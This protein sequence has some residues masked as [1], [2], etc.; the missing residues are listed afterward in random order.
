M[1]D[2]AKEQTL[3]LPGVPAPRK[4]PGPKP[5]GKAMTTAQRQAKFRARHQ[6]VETGERI[7]ATIRAL[8]RQFDLTESAVTFA[9]C[10]KDWKRAG[11]P[12]AVTK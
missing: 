6:R 3:N 12:Q 1:R 4:R 2:L 5:S 9:L 10:N 7:S 8:S 11:F